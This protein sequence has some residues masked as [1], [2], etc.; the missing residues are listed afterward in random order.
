MTK[1][2][3]T[4]QWDSL[5]IALLESTGRVASPGPHLEKWVRDAGFTNITHKKYK[6]PIGPW[7]KD[8]KL[9]EIGTCNLI[10]T[11]AGLE[12]F[13]LRMLCGPGGWSEA[14]ANGLLAKVREEMK[15]PGMHQQY[16]M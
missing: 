10:Q 7:A 14:E 13:S 8:P 5:I 15:R 9:K 3:A 6:L 12:A 11:L 4:H 16:D 2:S 1:D